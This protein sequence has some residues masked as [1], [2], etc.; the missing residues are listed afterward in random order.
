MT[1]DQQEEF[2]F[3]HQFFDS[4]KRQ[5]ETNQPGV[6][7][8]I[9]DISQTF[10]NDLPNLRDR[11]SHVLERANPDS[12][13]AAVIQSATKDG[14]RKPSALGA[15]DPALKDAGLRLGVPAWAWLSN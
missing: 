12:A 15:W 9:P 6:R 7:E 2:S 4:I 10:A 8:I 13:S 1:K 14:W 11:L 5:A 3:L